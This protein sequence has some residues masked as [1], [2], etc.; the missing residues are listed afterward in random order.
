MSEQPPPRKSSVMPSTPSP[1]TANPAA[2]EWAA[3]RGEKWLAQLSGMEA[4]LAPVDEPL[5]R[6]LQL[7]G[8]LRIAEIGSG[9][10]GTALEIVRRAPVGSVVH[11][12]DISP[13]LVDVARRRIGPEQRAV[14]FQSADMAT[15]APPEVPYDRLVSR[16]GIMFFDDAPAAFANLTRW[17]APGGRF[18]FAAWG[19][20]TDNPWMTSV[21]DAAAELVEIPTFDPEAPG[22]FRYA[23][24][25]KLL[26][27]LAAAGFGELD[28]RDWRGALPVGGGLAPAEAASFALATFA[29]FAE[30][31][32][33]AGGDAFNQARQSLTARFAAHQ[34]DGVVRMDSRVH[35]FT[36]AR[37]K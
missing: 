16:F 31:L 20:T 1:I 32:A 25:D 13:A 9:G 30:L 27:L 17:L 7:D 28:V 21:R 8:P 37:R 15:A 5:L 18:A 33:K 24:G 3:A 2:S 36:G 23:D 35:I 12:F 6:A 10:G 4:M 14:T 34:Q 29:S 26:T 22:A 19:P 11:G